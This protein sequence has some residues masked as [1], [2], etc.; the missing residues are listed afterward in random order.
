[1]LDI[2]ARDGDDEEICHLHIYSRSALSHQWINVHFLSLVCYRLL[3][4]TIV[5]FVWSNASGALNR[6]QSGVPRLVLPKDFFAEVGVTIGTEVNRGLMFL[7]DLACRG[8]LK[9]FLMAAIGLWLAAMIESCCNFLTVLY[10]GFV[11]AHTMPV[12]YE[13]Y[14]DEVDGF[15]DSL[16]MKFHS[17]YKKMDTGF[18]SRI[19]SGRFGFKKHD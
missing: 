5:Q 4:G 17:H 2:G 18:L 15:V 3:L 10:I 7:Q 16:L 12:L 6:S 19:P 11:G 1:M 13:K 9:Q 8:S 14:E